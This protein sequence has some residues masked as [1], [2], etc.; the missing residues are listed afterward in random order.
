MWSLFKKCVRAAF[1]AVASVLI[2]AASVFVRDYAMS[3]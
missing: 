3:H 2:Q 1:V